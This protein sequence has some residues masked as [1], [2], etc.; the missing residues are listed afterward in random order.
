MNQYIVTNFAYGTGPYLRTTD[1]AIAFNDE[2]EKAGRE[3]MGIIVPWVYGEKQKRV[4][5]EE[6]AV[7]EKKY[8]GEILLDKKLGE[9]LRSVFYADCTYEEA[10][11]AWV[12]QYREVSLQA[13]HH[14]SFNF[15]VET[16]GGEKR[17]VDGTKISVELNRSPRIRYNVAPSYFTSF[18]Y[19]GDI[20]ERAQ[21]VP[22]I[23]VDP[24]LLKKGVEAANWI[25]R[26]QKMRCM[27]WPATFA[28]LKP[29]LRHAEHSEASLEDERIRSFA[30]ARV[31]KDLR[32]D[33]EKGGRYNDEILVPPIAPPPKPNNEEIDPGI[34][35]TITGIPG[36]ERLYADAKRLG[37]KYY[38]ND[39][40]AVPGSIHALPHIIPNTR[41]ALQFARSGWSSIWI[42]MIS[43][44]PLVVP[45][46]D[47]HDD[48]EIYFNN[49]SV[50]EL[51]LG[52]VYRGQPLEEIL[53]ETPRIK[54]SY[55]K[56]TEVIMKRWGTL[57]GN[58]YCAKM[59]VEDY[60][61]V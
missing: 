25:E 37:L 13:Y 57:D 16:L 40:E 23:A 28:Y 56:V 5:L 14:F 54:E 8:A 6:F 50:E 11:R 46:F 12:K 2:L 18:A 10:L 9:L 19:L 31:L 59:F 22:E 7:H 60:L 41:I 38:S 34:F 47:S 4:M 35:V 33:T 32:D 44:T 21:K 39:T 29:Y 27:A 3:R 45:E 52:I 1:L 53:K 30:N 49:K 24:E 48:P 17:T 61:K 51:G 20:L 15:E 26:I 36:L 55:K 58:R 42:S 43:G